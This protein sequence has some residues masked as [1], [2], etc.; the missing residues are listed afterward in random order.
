MGRL[1]VTELLE[2]HAL[3]EM[4]K[5]EDDLNFARDDSSGPGAVS[6]TLQHFRDKLAK[7][8]YEMSKKLG[9]LRGWLEDVVGAK[10]PGK[11]AGGGCPFQFPRSRTHIFSRFFFSYSRRPSF[12]KFLSPGGVFVSPLSPP[13]SLRW[14][15]PPRV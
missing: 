9:S 1:C 14:S 3:A 13:R 12:N 15:K 8:P 2:P 10:S 6:F 11:G 4:A 5:V 7:S